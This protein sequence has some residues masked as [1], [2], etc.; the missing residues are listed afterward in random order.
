M[1]VRAGMLTPSSNTC[2]EPVTYRM[3]AGV[4]EVTAHFS[5]LPVTRIGLDPEA[6]AQFTQQPMLAAARLLADAKV[7]VLAWNGTAGSWLG[8]DQDREL[9]GMVEKATGIPTTTS[10][11]A[12][13][14]AFR[15]Y[16]VTRLGVATP[17]GD[18]VGARIAEHYAAEGVQ[19]VVQANLGITDNEAFARVPQGRIRDLVAAAA[20]ADVHAVAVVCTNLPAAPLAARLERDLGVPVLDSVAA[21]L[22]KALDVAGAKVSLSG[23]G[24]L[25][26]SGTL[27]ARFQDI[28]DELLDATGCDRTTLRLDIPVLGLEVAVAAAE[29][30]HPGV[31]SIRRDASLDQRRLDTVVWLEDNRRNLVQPDFHGEPRAPRALI[32]LYGVKAQLLGPVEQD[33]AMAGWLSAH[34]L[35][36]RPW[37]HADTAALDAAK[38]R[39]TS[40]LRKLTPGTA[41]LA[42]PGP[43]PPGSGSSL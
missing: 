6:S 25:L 36:E 43:I 32:D 14:D 16:G 34:S 8:P 21:T 7:D 42:L 9:A 11:L 41:S 27:R 33:G 20:G 28:C 2:L 10:T 37:T 5:R 24:T 30:L 15:A 17:Y 38:A 3:L 13:L 26:D 29:A 4:E 39:V 12:L 31:P 18:E 35:A 1:S 40:V 23:W 19:V 22:W